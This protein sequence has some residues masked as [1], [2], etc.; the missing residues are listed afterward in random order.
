MRKRTRLHR[1]DPPR[2]AP[3]RNF[4]NLFQRSETPL[5]REP[6]ANPVPSGETQPK[7]A[8]D[9]PVA[10]A[11][12][13]GYR[14]IES[15]LSAG[16]R[17]AEQFNNQ[18]YGPRA[19]ASGVPEL[20]ER[21]LRGYSEMVPTWLELAGS[22]ARVDRSPAPAPSRP[23]LRRSTDGASNHGPTT[24]AIEVASSKPVRVSL[25]LGEQSDGLPLVT[26]G[27][28]A[29]E[30]DRAPLTDISFVTAPNNGHRSLRIR[31]PK[32][33]PPGRYSG[34]VVDQK[35]GEPRGTLSVRIVD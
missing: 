2:T 9:D 19:I 26:H 31:I 14:V 13:V 10:Q 23:D 15:Y 28:H 21:I 8:K 18:P 16:R 34:V 29:L 25:Q 30:P 6:R 24:V 22:L 12:E 5:G 27:L 17:A 1:K 3:I 4:S 33:Q 7:A 35:T 20:L 32:G 11:V